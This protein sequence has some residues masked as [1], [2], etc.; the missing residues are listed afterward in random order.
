MPVVFEHW[1]EDSLTDLVQTLC[2]P[3]R[4]LS[5]AR[6]TPDV[7]GFAPICC[8][9]FVYFVEGQD[10]ISELDVKRAA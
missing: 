6:E 1:R 8:V 9:R 10:T 2:G 3:E 4:D 7:L 5:A